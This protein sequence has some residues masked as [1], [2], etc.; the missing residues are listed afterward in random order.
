MAQEITL[1]TVVDLINTKNRDV[2]AHFKSIDEKLDFNFRRIYQYFEDLTEVTVSSFDRVY[3][4]MD[5]GF[6]KIDQKFEDLTNITIEG[7][8][9]VYEQLSNHKRVAHLELQMTAIN[10]KLGLDK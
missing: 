9:E 10:A 7:F 2:D 3:T 5:K 6:V 1:Q 8:D 4:T